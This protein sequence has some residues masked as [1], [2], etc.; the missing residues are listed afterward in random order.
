M[1]SA[2]RGDR[3]RLSRREFFLGAGGTAIGVAGITGVGAVSA[4]MHKHPMFHGAYAAAVRA[5][6][7][8]PPPSQPRSTIVWS[9]PTDQKRLALT[10]DDGPQPDWT[11]RVL[12]VLAKHDVR[13]TFFVCGQSVDDYAYLHDDS[14]GVHEFGNH[15][16]DHPELSLL[17]YDACRSQLERTQDI[18]H[19]RLGTRPT[20]FR[21]PYGYV[22][23]SML[24]AASDLRLT[25]VLWSS[26]MPEEIYLD[27]PKD[28]V[29]YVGDNAAPGDVWLAHDTGPGQ[30]LVTIAYLDAIIE[31]LIASGFTLTTVSDLVGAPAAAG[32]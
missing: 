20:L 27:D 22:G 3:L 4:R 5:T 12:E 17:D 31:R 18:V 1:E 30:R 13:A 9:G 14:I 25:T 26:R 8:S 21:P 32:A 19:E 29:D 23:G 15:S 10:F 11:P 16:W 28:V 6:R 2:T 7:T 24:L